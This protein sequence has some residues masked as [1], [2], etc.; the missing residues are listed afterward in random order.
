MKKK[1]PVLQVFVLIS[2][3]TGRYFFGQTFDIRKTLFAF[4]MGNRDFA[5]LHS[6]VEVLATKDVE[7]RQEGTRIETELRKKKNEDE[8]L[9]Y[10]FYNNFVIHYDK[11]K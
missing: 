8:I 1:A 7:D 9:L 6:P 10:L 4:N 11:K 2:Q 3:K 5:Q